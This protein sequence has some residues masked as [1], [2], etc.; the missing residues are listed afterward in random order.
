MSSR[1]GRP[2][3][4]PKDS[5]FQIRISADDRKKLEYCVEK[6]GLSKAEI[7]RK[8]IREVYDGLKK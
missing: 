5:V 1:T 8:G 6:T 3:D 4:D 2:T 7:I